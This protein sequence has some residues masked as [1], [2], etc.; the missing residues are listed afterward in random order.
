MVCPGT[1]SQWWRPCPCGAGRV[2]CSGDVRRAKAASIV[3]RRVWSRRT[4][5]LN[6]S[7]LLTYRS[8]EHTSELQ[9]PCNLVCRLLLEKKQMK[10]RRDVEEHGQPIVIT[11]LLDRNVRP[12][13]RHLFT[14]R[15]LVLVI[16]AHHHPKNIAALDPHL[17]R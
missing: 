5:A 8:E 2:P 13:N 4:Q 14:P 15:N 6:A 7:V 11:H 16:A 3:I 10:L 12:G 1:D 9:S 17:C